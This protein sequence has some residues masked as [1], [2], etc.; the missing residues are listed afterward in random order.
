MV[1]KLAKVL[2][3]SHATHGSGL[4]LI[5]C[6]VAEERP[7]ED[8]VCSMRHEGEWPETLFYATCQRMFNP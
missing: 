5:N 7:H 2:S 3:N 4:A 6:I 8:N 1:F